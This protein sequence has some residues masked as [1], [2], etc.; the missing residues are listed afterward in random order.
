MLRF[1]VLLKINPDPPILAFFSISLLFL[2]Y[3]FPCFS[4]LSLPFPRI[5]GVPRRQKPLLFVGGSGNKKASPFHFP[6]LGVG[7]GRGVVG[8][9][10]VCF[11]CSMSRI[12]SSASEAAAGASSLPPL[13]ETFLPFSLPFRAVGAMPS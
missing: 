4:P 5:F 2:F 7:K 10:A 6:K 13:A 1:R 8:R 9:G 11:H 3:D 12:P